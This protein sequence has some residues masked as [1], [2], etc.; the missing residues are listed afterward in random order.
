MAVTEGGRR[1]SYKEEPVLSDQ[2]IQERECNQII[3][4][5]IQLKP[6]KKS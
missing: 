1:Y 5:R 3:T 6:F 2:E 4:A